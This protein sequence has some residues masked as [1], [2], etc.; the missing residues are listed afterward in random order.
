MHPDGQRWERS[1][2]VS[3]T[4][5]DTARAWRTAHG[6]HLQAEPGDWWVTTD[7]GRSHSVAPSAFAATYQHVSEE[8]YR[9]IGQVRAREAL[10]QESVQT[11]EGEARATPGDWILTDEQGN[12]W[13]VPPEEFTGSYRP[14]AD[15]T[16][17]GP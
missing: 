9:R 15:E 17:P 4:R 13:P 2:R 11:L 6:D 3:A 8:V 14:L 1:G 7:D 5:L 10:I 16:E 12:R